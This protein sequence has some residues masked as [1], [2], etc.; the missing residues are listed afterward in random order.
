M[1]NFLRWRYVA[2]CFSLAL[3]AFFIVVMMGRGGMHFGVDFI[4]GVKVI[5]QFTTD[6]SEGEIRDAFADINAQIQQIGEASQNQFII[7]TK[8]SDDTEE[9]SSQDLLNVK[10]ILI[11]KYP[12]TKFLSEETVGPAVGDILKRS[13]VKLFIIALIFMAL[14][15][16]FRF[17]WKYAFGVMV[18]LMHDMILTFFFIGF[19]GIEMNIPIVAALLT[20]FGYTVNDT[21]VIFDRIRENVQFQS[22]ETYVE[23]INKSLNQTMSRTLLTSLTSLFTVVMLYIFGGDVLNDFALVLIFGIVIGTYSSIYIASPSIIIWEKLA[24]KKKAH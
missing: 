11:D 23:I 4:G 15:L 9:K 10:R 6:V 22:K 3:L 21:I 1:I 20:I 24:S 14:Y 12:D 5:A 8:L 13:A 2:F 18:S 19:Q 17:E 7:S 16:A